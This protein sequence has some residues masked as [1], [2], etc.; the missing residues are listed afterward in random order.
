MPCSSIAT[1]T[2]TASSLTPAAW[3]SGVP[4]SMC[5]DTHRAADAGERAEHD[6]GQRVKSQSQARR[7][8]HRGG[9]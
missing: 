1:T 8:D 7:A 9:Q 6:F 2:A 5:H 3:S 4:A